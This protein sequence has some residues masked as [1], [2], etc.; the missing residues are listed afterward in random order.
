VLRGGLTA[1][2]ADEAGLLL[3]LLLTHGVRRMLDDCATPGE[4]EAAVRSTVAAASTWKREPEAAGAFFSDCSR[5]GIAAATR[6]SLR[7][8]VAVAVRHG[9]SVGQAA[10]SRAVRDECPLS[11]SLSLL[12]EAQLW[13]AVLETAMIGGAV[14]VQKEEG[15]TVWHGMAGTAALAV[16]AVTVCTEAA[17]SEG[18]FCCCCVA[19]L[20]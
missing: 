14:A 2:E 18:R 11:E 19:A 6:A 15:A 17:E 16:V 3:L 13:W 20:A 12:S 7:G 9:C 4:R 5:A 8:F 10:A 1:V